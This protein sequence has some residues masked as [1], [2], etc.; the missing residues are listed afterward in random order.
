MIG[1]VHAAIDTRERKAPP[2]LALLSVADF[3][4]FG[5]TAKTQ[6]V[7][8]S[9]TGYPVIDTRIDRACRSVFE[10]M[11]ESK[12]REEMQLSLIA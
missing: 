10:E 6:L 1:R 5:P 7:L 11:L 3:E 8:G 4:S 2:G 9:Q 12:K